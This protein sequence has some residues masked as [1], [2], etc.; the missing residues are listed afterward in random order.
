MAALLSTK[1]GSQE[2]DCW[3]LRELAPG[4]GFAGVIAA[5]GHNWELKCWQ[6]SE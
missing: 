5:Q 3:S 1:G 6:W 2:V 4:C